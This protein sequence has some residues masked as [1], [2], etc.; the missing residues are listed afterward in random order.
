MEKGEIAHNEQFLHFLQCFL[1]VS[2]AFCHFHQISNCRLPTLSA[3]KSLKFVVWERVN[4]F[5]HNSD[6]KRPYR[7]GTFE[8]IV[9]KG[10][11]DGNQHF[12]LFPQCFLPFQRQVSNFHS[13]SCCHFQMLSIWIRLKFCPLLKN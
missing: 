3:W 5:S 11:N 12:L 10:E 1:P 8:N 7:R 4:S 9:G 2:K 13:L 6:F